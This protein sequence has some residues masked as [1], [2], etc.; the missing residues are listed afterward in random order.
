MLRPIFDIVLFSVNFIYI[1]IGLVLVMF[2]IYLS[3]YI[4]LPLI[5]IAII[6]FII[7]QF[8]RYAYINITPSVTIEPKYK[9]KETKDNSNIIDVDYTEIK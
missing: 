1:L 6:L 9:K 5:L 7:R 8:K 2:F 3:A 4:A